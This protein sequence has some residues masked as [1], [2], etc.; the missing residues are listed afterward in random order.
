LATEITNGNPVIIWGYLGSGKTTSWHTPEDKEIQAVYYEHT[1]LVRGFAGESSNPE[2]FFLID[3]IYGY[4]Y[5]PI[6][7]FMKKW[8]AFGRSGVVVY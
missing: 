5:Y 7:T 6:E 4:I 1:F 2:G 8:N 3:P